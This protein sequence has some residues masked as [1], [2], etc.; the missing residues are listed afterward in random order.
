ML[1]RKTF[2]RLDGLQVKRPFMLLTRPG[3]KGEGLPEAVAKEL[4]G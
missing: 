3:R 4:A 1:G 2:F